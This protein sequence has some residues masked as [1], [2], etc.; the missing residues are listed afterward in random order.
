MNINEH[1]Y[2]VVRMIIKYYAIGIFAMI[3][4]IIEVLAGGCIEEKSPEVSDF[5]ISNFKYEANSKNH[6]VTWIP[7]KDWSSPEGNIIASF[8]MVIS[9]TKH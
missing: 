1:Y 7:K 8:S 5:S 9:S 2:R 6:P 3:M 4:I